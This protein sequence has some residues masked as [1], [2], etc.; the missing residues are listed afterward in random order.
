MECWFF[1][2][3][4]S[5]NMQMCGVPGII[6]RTNMSVPHANVG[7]FC[8]E[9]SKVYRSSFHYIAQRSGCKQTEETGQLLVGAQQAPSSRWC[10]ND[11]R[12]PA[13]AL[14]WIVNT[15]VARGVSRLE[16][17]GL[18]PTHY[19]SLG[20][21]FYRKVRTLPPDRGGAQAVTDE[22]SSEHFISARE[23][24]SFSFSI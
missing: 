5:S 7:S 17:N 2:R 21:S 10:G 1:V 23:C 9:F 6:L 22:R 20:A 4:H 24:A 11:P 15:N 14:S 3:F 19:T 12:V 13:R 16:T 18:W 8:I